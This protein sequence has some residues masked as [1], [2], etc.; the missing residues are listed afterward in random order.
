M[1]YWDINYHLLQNLVKMIF[2]ISTMMHET[3][4]G[5]ENYQIVIVFLCKL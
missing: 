2:Q 1:L 5:I 3:R 4:I